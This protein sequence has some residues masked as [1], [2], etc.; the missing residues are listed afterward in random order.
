MLFR[1]RDS[2]LFFLAIL[3][4]ALPRYSVSHEMSASEAPSGLESVVS[5]DAYSQEETTDLLV[6]FKKGKEIFL[7]HFRS[8]DGGKSWPRESRLGIP[9]EKIRS[10]H[11]GDDPQIAAFGDHV[12]VLWT[13]PGTSRSP[14]APSS[15]TSMSGSLSSAPRRVACRVRARVRMTLISSV[16]RLATVSG[17]LPSRITGALSCPDDR[18]ERACGSQRAQRHASASPST[19]PMRRHGP[20]WRKPAAGPMRQDRRQSVSGAPSLWNRATGAGG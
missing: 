16:T 13:M 12:V 17:S 5:L 6:T 8:F 2:G 9:A 3:L 14:R 10:P 4:F 20:H 18:P 7:K 11:R 1:K 15:T 19:P